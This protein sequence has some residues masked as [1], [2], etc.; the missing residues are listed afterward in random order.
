M[1]HLLHAGSMKNSEEFPPME[2]F[3]R[4]PGSIT[5]EFLTIGIAPVGPDFD[6]EYSTDVGFWMVWLRLAH[7]HAM[8]SAAARETALVARRAG[9]APAVQSALWSEFRHGLQA[10]TASAYSLEALCKMLEAR[11][12]VD[13]ETEKRRR[14]RKPWASRR[15]METVLLVSNIPAPRMDRLRPNIE[16]LFNN[17]NAS[18][19]PELDFKTNVR[20]HALDVDVNPIYVWCGSEQAVGGFAVALEFLALA[21]VHVD[22]TSYS[23]QFLRIAREGLVEFLREHPDLVSDEA[24]E[25]ADLIANA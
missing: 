5:R 13:E 14:K 11:G 7:D 3:P 25:L 6:V 22:D 24:P 16:Q 15:V 23:S 10:V 4:F 8:E 17:R 20:H 9:D 12:A 18:V 2:S 1:A 19:H 21:V